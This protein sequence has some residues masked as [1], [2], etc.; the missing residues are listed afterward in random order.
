M[1]TLLVLPEPVKNQLAL[2]WILGTERARVASAQFNNVMPP[3]PPDSH[4]TP[5]DILRIGPTLIGY[6]HVSTEE[7]A[8]DN[9]QNGFR[10]GCSLNLSFCKSESQRDQAKFKDLDLRLQRGED[11]HALIKEYE[12]AIT[13]FIRGSIYMDH[14]GPTLTYGDF[15]ATL[16]KTRFMI[17]KTGWLNAADVDGYGGLG[18]LPKENVGPQNITLLRRVGKRELGLNFE[19]NRRFSC[20]AEELALANYIASHYRR[21]LLR[22]L[23]EDFDPSQFRQVVNGERI[24][25]MREQRAAV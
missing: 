3:E 20:P 24:L 15:F 4:F 6:R 23:R 22:Y 9:A 18:R 7:H 11:C 16:D 21:E 5:D 13:D 12:V 8:Q 25:A 19:A 17:V 2:S 1:P 14:E 10:H